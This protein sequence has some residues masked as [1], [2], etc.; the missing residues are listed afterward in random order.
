M[1]V[2]D[3]Q[4]QTIVCGMNGSKV[5]LCSTGNCIQYAVTEQNGKC[6]YVYICLGRVAVQQKLA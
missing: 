2:W 5:L 3:Q 6:M 1:G 4:V